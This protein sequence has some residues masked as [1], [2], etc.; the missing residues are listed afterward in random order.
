MVLPLM[1]G[2]PL[3]GYPTSNTRV[4][5]A[6]LFGLI[7]LERYCRGMRARSCQASFVTLA[8]VPQQPLWLLP[9]PRTSPPGTQGDV[10]R[11][12]WLS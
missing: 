8:Q 9:S 2:R 4:S 11:C 3:P 5:W 1:E 10:W 12:I 7:S 6:L